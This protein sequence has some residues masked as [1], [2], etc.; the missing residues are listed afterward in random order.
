M[1]FR[2][3]TS[4]FCLFVLCSFAGAAS[5]PSVPTQRQPVTNSYHGEVVVDPYQWL[6]DVTAPD[7]PVKDWTRLQNERTR[8]F[9]SRLPYRDGIAQQLTQLRTDESARYLALREKKGRIF[10]L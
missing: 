6:E 10:A 9:Y 1:R 4:W 3:I 7:S 5:L 2:E 8:E